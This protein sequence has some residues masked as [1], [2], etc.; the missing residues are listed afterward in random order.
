MQSL[1]FGKTKV[2]KTN[3]PV[4]SDLF[5]TYAAFLQ[6]YWGGGEEIGAE[7]FTASWP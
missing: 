5:K 6:G 7:V 3:N 1:I 4:I 2:C